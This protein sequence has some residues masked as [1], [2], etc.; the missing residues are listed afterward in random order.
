MHQS[1]DHIDSVAA[2]SA[3]LR[4]RIRQALACDLQFLKQHPAASA[5]MH[6]LTVAAE[7]HALR[8]APAPIATAAT[9]DKWCR[10]IARAYVLTAR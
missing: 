1:L 4:P 7:K 9:L 8:C 3:A 5:K 10:V 6:T 2:E